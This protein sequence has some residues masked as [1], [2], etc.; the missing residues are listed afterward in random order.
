MF[1]RRKASLRSRFS[2]LALGPERRGF[3]QPFLH[4]EP[5]TC[6]RGMD[7]VP[8]PV[9]S[10]C[11]QYGAVKGLLVFDQR[12][13]VL[14]SQSPNCRLSLFDLYKLLCVVLFVFADRQ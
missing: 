13:V 12:Q 5:M 7:A 4:H 6:I 14:C 1:M 10:W 11:L 3:P 8:T 2:D 9:A